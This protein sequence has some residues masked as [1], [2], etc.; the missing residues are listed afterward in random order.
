ME[1]ARIEV[2][3]CVGCGRIEAPAPRVGICRDEKVE[4]VSAADHDAALAQ[5][6]AEAAE[7]RKVLHAIA[8][9]TPRAGEWERGYRALQAEA[10][11]TLA[12]G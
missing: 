3:E 4:Y 6:R 8:H 7:L 9:T 5:A 12:T 2:W 11:R 1:V 10:R